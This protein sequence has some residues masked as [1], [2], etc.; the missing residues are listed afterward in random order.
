MNCGS[1]K[2]GRIPEER[3]NSQA[4]DEERHGGMLETAM[5]TTA[6]AGRVVAAAISGPVLGGEDER[7]EPEVRKDDIE[8]QQVSAV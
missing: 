8:R 6:H 4:D 5:D 2:L 7:R 1:D 3:G